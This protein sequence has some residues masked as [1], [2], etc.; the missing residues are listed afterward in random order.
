MKRFVAFLALLLSV[1]FTNA[2]RVVY[3]EPDKSDYRQTEFEIIGKVGGNLLI[4]KNT[5]STYSISVYD[6]DMKQKSRVKMEFLPDRIINA[7]FLAYPDHC[8]M[9][10]QYQK[11]NVVYAM[12]ARLDNGGNIVG[13]PIVMDTTEIGFLASNKIY[14]V[15]NSDD[16]EYIGLFKINSKNED[17]F[18]LTTSVF[19]KSLERIDKQY[20]GIRMPERHDYLTEFVIDNDGDLAF[21]KAIQSQENDKISK[22]YFFEKKL[23]TDRLR[24]NQI[25]LNNQTLDDIRV[26]VDNYNKH[27]IISSFFST[28]R[29]G[30]IEGLFTCIWDKAADVAKSTVS[31]EFNESLRVDAKGDNSLK[32]AFND[33]FIRNLIVRKD[34]GFLLAAESF[35]STGRGGNYNRY[36]YLYGSPF[37]RPMDYYSFSPYGY[38]YPWYRYNSLG[39]STRYNAQNIAVFSFD[40][41]GNMVWNNILNK[42]QYDDETDAFIGY[43]LLNTGDQLH[44]LFNQ[45]EKRL[46]LLNDQ[47]ISPS[48]QV[49]RNPTLKNLDQGYDFM[50]RYG[51]QVG[52][53]QIIFPCIYRNNLCFARLDL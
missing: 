12:T 23:G 29:R 32:S 35:F 26:K 27:Y 49:T 53:R 47:S 8:Y 50:A 48:G 41:T 22:L 14:S 42:N 17:N 46:Q 39:Q 31:F 11:R 9:F 37:L 15:I 20:I 28:S 25:Q 2:Q 21:V 3:S 45:Q 33:Y 19:N 7:D 34:G 10:Y 4:Y 40:S 5:R 30:N 24:E 16:K 44:F 18:L 36:D 6:L 43:S 1:C 51:K 13:K 38:G 52:S